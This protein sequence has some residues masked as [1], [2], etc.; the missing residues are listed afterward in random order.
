MQQ[1]V[2]C[3]NLSDNSRFEVGPP[4]RMLRGLEEKRLI[5]SDLEINDEEIPVIVRLFHS[6]LVNQFKPDGGGERLRI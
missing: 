2:S 1:F 6:N 5:I 3:V 4:V